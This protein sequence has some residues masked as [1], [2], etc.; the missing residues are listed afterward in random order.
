MNLT[1][2]TQLFAS[3]GAKEPQ[4]WAASQIDEGIPQLHRFLFLRQ[5]WQAVLSPDNLDWIDN[6]QRAGTNGH[7]EVQDAL[8]RLLAAGARREDLTLVVRNMQRE[9][10]FSLCYL[11]ENPDVDDLEVDS[12][13]WG[14]FAVDA[15]GRAEQQILGL[16]E[17]VL[18]TDPK[19]AATF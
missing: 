12:I 18:E 13:A 19:T 8:V 14:L 1:Q 17:S 11:M 2:L 15:E 7:A 3:L 16:H 6:L 10:L 9:L 5:A 4:R